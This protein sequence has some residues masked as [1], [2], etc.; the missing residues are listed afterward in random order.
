M[1]KIFILLI[2]PILW[3]CAMNQESLKEGEVKY[4]ITFKATWSRATHPE[5]FP[6][7]SH[8]SPLIGVAHNDQAEFWSTGKK[9]SAGIEEMAETGKTVQIEQEMGRSITD[10]T[11]YKIL[12]GSRS[13]ASPG[14]VSCTFTTTKDFPL[15]TLVSMLAPS[16]DWFTGVSGHNLFK[17][18]S[19]IQSEEFDV[20]VYDAGTDSGTE[21][22]SGDSDTDPKEN[23]TKLTEGA[24]AGQGKSVIGQFRLEKLPQ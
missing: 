2:S 18:G 22:T 1:R 24:F 10:G 9:S 17:D 5:N 4:Q 15:L 23:I 7:G 14:T 16:P 19:W 21:F 8:F 3:A 13:F 20:H 11:S 6:P 12:K